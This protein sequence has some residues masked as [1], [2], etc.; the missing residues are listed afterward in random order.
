[1]SG[2]LADLN[3]NVTSNISQ[4]QSSLAV[5]QRQLQAAANTKVNIGANLNT[6]GIQNSIGTLGSVISSLGGYLGNFGGYF[7]TAGSGVSKFGNVINNT[8]NGLS[9][10]STTLITGGLAA[11]LFSGYGIKASESINQF[12]KGL[13]NPYLANLGS[14]V[15]KATDRVNLFVNSIRNYTTGNISPNLGSSIIN[16]SNSVKN[17]IVEMNNAVRASASNGVNALIATMPKTSS[18]FKNLAQNANAII[19]KNNALQESLKGIS[20]HTML[21][22]KSLTSSMNELKNSSDAP[23][24]T[25]SITALG[26]AIGKLRGY[27]NLADRELSELVSSGRFLPLH[28]QLLNLGR[29]IGETFGLGP[30]MNRISSLS[31]SFSATLT[32]IRLGFLNMISPIT[33]AF[34][35][36]FSRISSTMGS[37]SN[38]I[39]TFLAPIMAQLTM[40]GGSN[41]FNAL[42]AGAATFLGVLTTVT[43]GFIALGAAMAAIKI[44]VF[45]G[46]FTKIIQEGM[47]Y[48]RQ[49]EQIKISYAVLLGRE[50]DKPDWGK[51][52][53]QSTQLVSQMRELAN[54]TPLITSD[55][56]EAG[57]SLMAFGLESKDLLA[58]EKMIG[59][60]AQGNQDKF[61]RLAY[62]Y[63]EVIAQGRLTGI[64]NR[65]FVQAGFNPLQEMVDTSKGITVGSLKKDMEDGKIGVDQV[66]KAFI[67]ATSEGGTFYQMMERQAQTFNGRLSTL[68]DKWD[69]FKGAVSEPIFNAFSEGL[70]VVLILLERLSEP[71]QLVKIKADIDQYIVPALQD[72]GKTLMWI[73]GLRDT[74]DFTDPIS[75]SIKSIASLIRGFTFVVKSIYVVYLVADT[76]WKAFYNGCALIVTSVA[77]AIGIIQVLGNALMVV[78]D[79]VGA[80]ATGILGVVEGLARSIAKVGE[81]IAESLIYAFT[82]PV[83]LIQESL[84]GLSS[85][86]NNTIGQL[87]GPQM[88]HFSI[89]VG[90]DRPSLA[91]LVNDVG[92]AFTSDNFMFSGTGAAL[93]DISKQVD[94][95][96]DAGSNFG[97]SMAKNGL[98]VMTE[99]TAEIASNIDTIMN[100]DDL[101]GDMSQVND[102]IDKLG[103]S[104]AKA[105]DYG[106]PSIPTPEIDDSDAKKAAEEAAKKLLDAMKDVGKE[107]EENTK[108]IVN[109]GNVFEKMT[110]E[111]FSPAKLINRLKRF[112]KEITNWSVNLESLTGKM[113]ETAINELRTM[114]ISGF[115]ITKGLANASPTQLAQIN[116]MYKGASLF[117][118][119]QAAQQVQMTHTGVIY[120]K[121]VNTKDELNSVVTIVA[122]DINAK[123][124]SYSISPSIMDILK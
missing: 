72:L 17:S 62:A 12:F 77:A 41:A 49:L 20:R 8:N 34:S 52:L 108:K 88:G 64:Q 112:L 92:D 105:P 117:G 121:G 89:S 37:I 1:M 48:N 96:V 70:N 25:A 30:L 53:S 116:Q 113:P 107:I 51:Q 3:I 13:R 123:A 21:A 42:V 24:H 28:T 27:L 84:N 68:K 93:E 63:G 19:L 79:I 59:D 23:L 106:T 58:T 104:V 2:N 40:I 33:D 118:L 26:V 54:Y 115:G 11:Q 18:V 81:F 75:A 97:F 76:L 74:V 73:F 86:W 39:T 57:T 22:I 60:I 15:K 45:A 124:N 91:D 50:F 119:N 110:Y 94:S 5:L 9:G 90:V 98:G 35:N 99:T 78:I 61:A 55:L 87:G 46:V 65:M 111:K 43:A 29:V 85:L 4:V 69:Q 10:F 56:T 95:I 66:V 103:K 36:V 82:H 14:D 31:S 120:V 44:I 67:K 47:E 71:T 83:A 101:F 6:S 100:L 16:L 7:S 122:K 109:F 80:V 114:G 32:N 38:R 102:F